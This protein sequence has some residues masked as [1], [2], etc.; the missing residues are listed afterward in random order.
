M[1]REHPNTARSRRHFDALAADY[2]QRLV[3]HMP[4]YDEMHD[5]IMALL[6]D[7]DGP[8]RVLELG[9]GTGALTRRVLQHF[10]RGA[11]VG[12]DLSKEMLARARPKLAFADARVELH[13]ADI[14]NASFRG[15]FDA[16][17]SA[18]AV[19][20]VP[21]RSKPKLFHRLFEALRP[22]GVLILGDAFRAPSAELDEVYR[23]QA[24]KEVERRGMDQQARDSFHR[25]ADRSGG[26]QA[27]VE[28]YLRWLRQA[29]FVSVDCAWKRFNLGVV[30]AVR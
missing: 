29:G 27:R 10:A 13:H 12:Y 20:H 7:D 3:A 26:T 21:P 1:P 25:R 19:H 14:S 30:Y 5:A 2:D 18:I 16:V 23:R 6:P 11:V 8:V 15:P 24:A 4:A 17:V 28:D 9:V 22:G